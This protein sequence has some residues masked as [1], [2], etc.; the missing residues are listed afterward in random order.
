MLPKINQRQTDPGINVLLVE[1][2]D[3]FRQGLA[4]YLRLRNVSV[5]EVSSGIGYFKAT[6]GTRYDVAIIDINLPD[7][8]GYELARDLS[9]GGLTGVIMLTARTGRDDRIKG[10]GAGADLYLTK[11]V[12]GEELYLAIQ[13]LARRISQS[14]QRDRHASPSG[15]W[16]LDV[17]QQRLVSPDGWEVTLTGREM[18]LMQYLAEVEQGVTVPRSALVELL[19]YDNLAPESRGL[20]AVLRRLRQKASDANCELP[21]HTVHALGIRFSAQLSVA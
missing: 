8:S 3:D 14:G 1:D 18:M 9:E 20:D 11:P 21:L 5:T 10:Y 4:D 6:R 2:D 19:G 15:S 17:S 16:R 7:I 13:N 12:D